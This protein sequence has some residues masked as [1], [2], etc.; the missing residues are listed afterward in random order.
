MMAC[1]ALGSG[2]MLTPGNWGLNGLELGRGHCK[3]LG[4]P[5]CKVTA[6]LLSGCSQQAVA[7]E[8]HVCVPHFVDVEMARGSDSETEWK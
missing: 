6:K 2:M 5:S 7:E 1:V 3:E 8:G 4:G